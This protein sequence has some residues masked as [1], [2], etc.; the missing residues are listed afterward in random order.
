MANGLTLYRRH[1]HR[2]VDRILSPLALLQNVETVI[3]FT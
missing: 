3:M 2:R 1:S